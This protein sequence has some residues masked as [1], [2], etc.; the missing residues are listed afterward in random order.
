MNKNVSRSLCKECHYRFRR[1]FI[2]TKPEEYFDA[3]DQSILSS[4]DNIIIV[5]QC[6]LTGMDITG[7]ETIECARF[8]RQNK[9]KP[10][11]LFEHLEQ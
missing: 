3:E 4:E 8:A 2:P 11:S 1:V 5:N 6:V 10:I 9:E 7:E